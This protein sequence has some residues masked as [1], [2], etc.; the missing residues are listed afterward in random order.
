[1]A[2]VSDTEDGWATLDEM[3]ASSDDESIKEGPEQSAPDLQSKVDALQEKIDLL[4]LQ[5][6]LKD[7][8]IKALT[9]RLDALQAVDHHTQKSC[10]TFKQAINFL[11]TDVSTLKNTLKDIETQ[12]KNYKSGMA[13]SVN[14]I[15]VNAKCLEDETIKRLEEQTDR[16]NALEI[17]LLDLIDESDERVDWAMDEMVDLRCNVK[18]IE[19]DVKDRIDSEQS[20]LMDR[21]SIVAIRRD[22]KSIQSQNKDY[23]TSIYG[24]SH[25]LQDMEDNAKRFE[26][27]INE[28]FEGQT[29]R[30]SALENYLEIRAEMNSDRVDR[31]ITEV[32]SSLDDAR[33]DKRGLQS[34][35]RLNKGFIRFLTKRVDAL[36]TNIERVERE[37]SER[38]DER[39]KKEH[40]F[41]TAVHDLVH[42]LDEDTK[43]RFEL[44]TDRVKALEDKVE[45]RQ[46]KAKDCINGGRA[47]TE[48]QSKVDAMQLDIE[49][50]QSQNKDYKSS[51]DA[52]TASVKDME[53]KAKRFE[54]KADHINAQGSA[55]NNLEKGVI[56]LD[57]KLERIERQD[58]ALQDGLG[59]TQRLIE[60]F[61]KS[62]NDCLMQ[63]YTDFSGLAHRVK[64]LEGSGQKGFTAT[65][66]N[67]ENLVRNWKEQVYALQHAAG[68][69]C[70]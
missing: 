38:L 19:K 11:Q 63:T 57:A 43:D 48:D 1:M 51:I 54:R 70:F 4:Q 69:G 21:S 50:L 27:E 20:T 5:T 59:Q 2:S 45:R 17:D 47:V 64:F 44:A 61:R 15:E 60:A 37:N 65:M 36:E 34:Q 67:Q 3:P 29:D 55:V 52:L 6:K 30:M 22:V 66:L 40:E 31:D 56:A 53:S 58:K 9:D 12:S 28:R 7:D 24:L 25:S 8:S 16:V 35:I 49:T 33:I 62:V 14:R 10:V 13:D 26:G 18:R 32:H 68:Y 23:D 41:I 39:L 42:Y 46:Q